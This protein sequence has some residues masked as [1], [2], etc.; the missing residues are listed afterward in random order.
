MSQPCISSKTDPSKKP[1]IDLPLWSSAT[2]PYTMNQHIKPVKGSFADVFLASKRGQASDNGVSQTQTFYALKLVTMDTP[3]KIDMVKNELRI[4]RQLKLHSHRN[5]LQLEDA[6]CLN[7]SHTVILA[8]LPYA[9]L[10][11]EQFFARTLLYNREKW[12]EPHRLSPWPE[13]MGQCLE[14]LNFLHTQEPQILHRDLKPQNILLWVRDDSSDHVE[15]RPIIT[16]FGVSTDLQQEESYLQGTSVYMSP[17]VLG[18]ALQTIYSDIWALGCCFAQIA[19]LLYSGER[20]LV[21]LRETIDHPDQRGFSKNLAKVES[22]LRSP[23]GKSHPNDLLE[24]YADVR[25]V[26]SR[27]LHASLK[28]SMS[29][30]T[31]SLLA[32]FQELEARSKVTNLYISGLT[33]FCRFGSIRHT[34]DIPGPHL[35]SIPD[36]LIRCNNES[37][38]LRS[39]L[40]TG[41]WWIMRYWPTKPTAPRLILLTKYKDGRQNRIEHDFPSEFSSK[42]STCKKLDSTESQA[43]PS[44]MKQPLKHLRKKI[45]SLLPRAQSPYL[46]QLSSSWHSLNREL[47]MLCS[48]ENESL[49]QWSKPWAYSLPIYQNV[50]NLSQAWNKA[51]SSC[52]KQ[53]IHRQ[54]GLELD[55]DA[56]YGM[57]CSWV[58]LSILYTVA[59]ITLLF[60]GVL[61][62]YVVALSVRMV[63]MLIRALDRALVDYIATWGTCPIPLTASSVVQ[64]YLRIGYKQC[65]AKWAPK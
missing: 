5:I 17:E 53:T 49:A 55:Y 45:I 7:D 3:T 16:D 46:K 25:Q 15:I 50:F 8:A 13:I 60:G 28:S 56:S 42:K 31:Q 35:C 27:M 59:V 52:S 14:G 37:T 54:C 4:L 57:L 26:V 65:R 9:P 30:T 47:E 39:A 10:S 33:I 62:F 21:E 36:L 29:Q 1:A 48:I 2:N 18:G 19:V 20:A 64:K 11:L 6:F 58:Y 41:S 63:T 23:D 38:R 12:Y 43:L 32:E 40:F 61:V 22:M 44:Y 51:P 34:L 24:C